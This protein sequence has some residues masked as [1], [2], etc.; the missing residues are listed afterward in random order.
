MSQGS[1]SSR[2]GSLNSSQMQPQS[3]M[4]QQSPKISQ[5]M[6]QMQITKE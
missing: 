1:S 5:R 4:L 2:P 3:A 6:E